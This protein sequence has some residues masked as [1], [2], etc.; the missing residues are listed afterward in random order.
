LI[1]VFLAILLWAVAVLAQLYSLTVACVSALLL[2]CGFFVLLR[3]KYDARAL[4]SVAAIIASL[5]TVQSLVIASNN[6]SNHPAEFVGREF[7]VAN[8]QIQLE[9]RIAQGFW[10]GS[11]RSF[12]G[13]QVNVD[14][15]VSARD[16]VKYQIGCSVD[17]SVRLVP[18]A[19]SSRPWLAKVDAD[20]AKVTCDNQSFAAILRADFLKSL[21]G[22]TS[23]SEALVAGLSIGDTS[24]LSNELSDRMK[25]LSL[26]H[27]TA[28][29]GANCAIVLALVFFLLGFIGLR[30]WQKVAISIACMWGYVQLVGP[31]PSVLRAA[32]MTAVIVVLTATGR[33][34]RPMAAL[35]HAASLLL[36]V[37]PSLAFSLGFALSLA[38]TGGI[39][40][41]TPWLYKNLK[42]RMPAALAALLSVSL[43]AQIW[44]TPILLQLQGGIPTY[45]L[46]ANVLVE[47]A[48]APITVLGIIACLVSAISGP[49]ASVII[50][51]ASIPAQYIVVV[52]NS[53]SERPV[54]TL[55]WPAGLLGVALMV[56]FAGAITLLA[57]NKRKRMAAAIMALSIL[58]VSGTGGAVVAR[59]ASWPISNWQ[60]V[61]CDVGQGD[62]LVIKSHNLVAVIDVGREP[63]PIDDCLN[64]LTI[65]TIDLLV[66]TH[67]DADHI[68]GLAGAIKNRS[69]GLAMLAD[70]KDE[71][72][73]A[74][75]VE[76]QVQSS[77][78]QVVRAHSGMQGKLG[79]FDWLVMQPEVGG[80]GAE[81]SNDGSIAMRW[82]SADFVLFTLA[83]LGERGQM[84]M[85]DLHPAWITVESNKPVVLKV[86]HHGSADQYPELLEYWK[87]TLSLI[88]VGASNGYGHPTTRTLNTL[89]G[90]NSQVFRTD[91]DGAISLVPNS[92]SGG[93]SVA[94]GG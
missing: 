60:V 12:D 73:Q 42:T 93:F 79:A 29:S 57:I 62:A 76:Y 55:W 45:S 66:L 39:L 9:G 67:F 86:S 91:Q 30:R 7:E 5:V 80:F 94:T 37:D 8:A 28:V 59:V 53:L 23:D 88:S 24:A 41:L 3:R 58:F 15:L 81:D 82:E 40:V 2:L 34:I 26:T 75:F 63:Q 51:F 50:W 92:T 1:P 85:A 21:S 35:A 38:A 56:L 87:P 6:N 77:A 90:V 18:N 11:V 20:S 70:F 44:C 43:A 78:K 17:A 74:R 16:D 25:K 71:R 89:E 46:L 4:L 84:R 33:S 69:V 83:D 61:N 54:A 36:L 27:L 22:V 48:V 49:L 14:T 31:Q 68:G 64:R 47:P 32:T 52:A 19:E 10:Q 72:P 65:N 13:K